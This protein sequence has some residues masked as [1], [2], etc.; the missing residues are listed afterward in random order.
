M[1]DFTTFICYQLKMTM[2]K[3]EKYIT[4]HLKEFGIN[5]PQSL[6]LFC[7]LEREGSTLSEIGSRAQIENSSLTTM[8]DKL[9]KEGL[10][11]RRMD[12]QNRRVTRL[13]LT[14]NGRRLAEEVFAAGLK[15]NRRLKNN[16]EGSEDNLIKALKT[17]SK[18]L[19]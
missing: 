2:R 1:Q 4:S 9:E 7:L 19:D 17:I 15:F 8:V 5:F 12:A 18:S 3:V 11:E 13:F 16:L 10:V 6:I 14:D